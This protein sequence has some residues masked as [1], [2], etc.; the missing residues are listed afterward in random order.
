MKEQMYPSFI[1][2]NIYIFWLHV[3]IQIDFIFN[4]KFATKGLKIAS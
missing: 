2:K 3:R 1:R 4:V